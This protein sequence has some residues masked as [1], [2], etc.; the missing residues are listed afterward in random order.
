MDRR[1]RG[2]RG[3]GQRRRWAWPSTRNGGENP[4]L[5]DRGGVEAPAQFECGEAF[6]VRTDAKHGVAPEFRRDNP[7][8]LAP[9]RL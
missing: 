4:C 8:E 1:G 2:T 6:T 7:L 9:E 3:G 5:D